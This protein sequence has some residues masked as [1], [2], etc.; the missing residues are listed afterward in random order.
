MQRPLQKRPIYTDHDL[1]TYWHGDELGCA[2]EKRV[3]PRVNE[4]TGCMMQW[5]VH[6][7]SL[8]VV[9]EHKWQG[10]GFGRAKEIRVQARDKRGTGW[11]WA[12]CR[13]HCGLYCRE[14]ATTTALGFRV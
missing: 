8:F 4:G 1:R 7:Q 6:S 3:Q 11:V 10:R 13:V 14:F 2:N 9:C 5:R 12:Q